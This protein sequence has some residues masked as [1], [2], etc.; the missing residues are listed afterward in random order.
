LKRALKKREKAVLENSSNEDAPVEQVNLVYSLVNCR[1]STKAAMIGL[2]ISMGATSLLVTR[3]SDQAL[4][5]EPVGNQNTASTLPAASD[6]EVKFSPTKSLMELPTVSSV[7]VPEHHAVVEPTAISQVSGLGAKLHTAR[8]MSVQAVAPVVVSSNIKVA[9]EQNETI[10]NPLQQTNQPLTATRKPSFAVQPPDALSTAS[11]EINAQLKAQ[12]EFAIN[13]LQQKSNRLRR[14]LAQFR[15]GQTNNL[16]HVPTGFMPSVAVAQTFPQTSTSETGTQPLE[17]VTDATR[18]A[19]LVSKLKQRSAQNVATSIPVTPVGVVT[20]TP[21]AYEVKPGDTL[22]QIASVYGTSV[23]NIVSANN[24]T[25][26]NQLQVSQKLT[27]PPENHSNA[28]ASSAAIKTNTNAHSVVADSNSSVPVLVPTLTNSQFQSITEPTPASRLLASQYNKP[29]SVPATAPAYGMGGDSPI[30]QAITEM[31]AATQQPDTTKKLKQNPRLRSL[32]AEIERLREKYRAQ[33]SGN[34][35][36][37]EVSQTS[38]VSEKIFVPQVSHQAVQ[39][40][41][42]PLNNQAN[43]AAATSVSRLHNQAVP[44]VVPKPMELNYSAQPVQPQVHATRS[45]ESD[46]AVNPEFLP[47]N[48]SPKFIIPTTNVD[49]SQSLGKL[50]GTT[51]SPSLPPLAAVDRYL[52]RPIDESTPTVLGYIWPAKGTLTSGFGMRW[53]RMHKGIDVANSVGTPVVASAD[54]VVE[55]AGWNNGGYGNLVDVRHPDGSLTRYG[56]NSKILVRAGQQVHQGETIA[57]MGSTGFST[58]P[59][60]HFEVHPSGKGAVNPIAFLPRL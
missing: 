53:G 11:S 41:V 33:Q 7:S 21:T 16:S 22:A 29:T 57:L 25:N 24:L 12:Q 32:Q 14:S 27:I 19:K 5:A 30:P 10:A 13:S 51:V 15:S 56:H 28:A 42:Y 54:G 2:A 40:P 23:S 49:A 1:M 31:Q 58:G 6:T 20:S 38:G 36:V 26:P 39:I 35:V 46:D 48:R 50:R 60:S 4:A 37:T 43:S 52:P 18:R 45:M 44:I 3:Q 8:Q 47:N 55:K 59:H 34:P 17:N 9:K